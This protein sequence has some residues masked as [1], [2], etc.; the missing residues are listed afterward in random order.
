MRILLALLVCLSL[1]ACGRPL[2]Q[3]EAAYM[4]GLQGESF[5]ASAV[6]IVENPVIGLGTRTY[7]ARDH[8]PRAHLAAPRW[9]HHRVPHRRDRAVQHHA[10]APRILAAR[11]RRSA[12]GT[13]QPRRS[14]VLRPRDDPCLAMAEPRG[15][16]LPPVPRLHRTCTDRGPL[17]L[18][19]ARRAAL[20][21]L[22]LRGAGFSCRRIRLLS[23]R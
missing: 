14:D 3:A 8:L 9:P 4:A 20:S 15:D 13:P 11:L 2:T 7:P 18:R 6:R 16:L 5:D 12:R 19:P 17:S 21:G 22:R 1:T 23:R 10:C